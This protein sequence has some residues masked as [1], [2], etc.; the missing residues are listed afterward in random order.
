MTTDRIDNIL[1][2]VYQKLQALISTDRFYV[3]FYDPRK[4]ELSFPLVREQDGR[5]PSNQAFWEKRRYEPSS[6]LP[7]YMIS[8]AQ[9]VLLKRDIRNR[10]GEFRIKYW[11]DKKY[12]YSWLGVPLKISEKAIGALVVESW[13]TSRSFS[14]T[15]QELLTTF[16]R[17]ASIA[18]TNA[19][20]YE[21]LERKIE[22]LRI[23]SRSGQQ[24]TRG[25]VK[26]EEEI[27]SLIYKSATDLQID[28]RNMYIAFYRPNA[29][30]PDT[31]EHIFG[32]LQFAL[33]YEDGRR[34]SLPDR[35][36]T[37]GLSG[38]VI[39]SK[40]S[41][42][43]ADVQKAY[44]SIAN[45]RNRRI[46]RS[47]LGVPMLSDGQVFGVIVLRNYDYEASYTEND[48]EMLEV[49]AGQAAVAMQNLRLYEA[50]QREQ[51]RRKAAE[52][53]G[54]M[55]LVAAEFAHKMNNLAGTIPVRISIAKSHLASNNP[56]RDEKV[57]EQLEKIEQESEGL[58]NAA[59]EIRRSSEKA[60]DEEVDINELLELAITRAENNQNRQNEVKIVR[61]LTDELPKT[62]VPRNAFL[63][64][65]TSIIKNGFE[66]IE[67]SGS[68]SIKTQCV[69]LHGEAAIEISITDT[70]RGIPSTE[71]SK[72][73]DL[74][75]STKG[76]KGLGFGL[77][78]DKII[79]MRLGG[80][81]DVQSEESKGST[82]V[83]RIPAIK[84]SKKSGKK[85]GS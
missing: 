60:V 3:I 73:Y 47:W 21:D 7:D 61:Q 51:E 46:P 63:D 72:I 42:N 2:A 13:Q 5:V 9:N 52:N 40:E 53:I 76:G 82:F 36:A 78:R 38:T 26:Q 56:G 59:Q 31:A 49:L 84:A 75:Y 19:R 55:S 22:N 18:I 15:D 50:Q 65:L 20:L 37:D 8:R 71:L 35:L 23:L 57:L 68:V 27:L 10:L 67:Q 6:W 25:L 79:I 48:Q 85:H 74:F 4:E 83:L 77:W 12:P 39:G 17:Q 24:F 64:T 29:E 41:F 70:G 54:L 44:E 16:A 14:E 45:Y 32:T 43:P 66:A 34:T 62:L 1:G 11:P 33:A 69:E 28:T 30:Q 58:L 80:E 81:I